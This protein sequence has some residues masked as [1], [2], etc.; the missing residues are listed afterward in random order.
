MLGSVCGTE[1]TGQGWSWQR[2]AGA[3]VEAYLY[4]DWGGLPRH[5]RPLGPHLHACPSPP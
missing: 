2:A 1:L 4:T 5:D 3:L